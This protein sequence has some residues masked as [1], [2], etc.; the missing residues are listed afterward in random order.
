M[1]VDVD[2]GRDVEPVRLDEPRVF[3]A[4]NVRAPARWRSSEE[5]RAAL[6]PVGALEDEHVWLRVA[7]LQRL[8][9]DHARE[10]AW[11]EAFDAMLGYAR[12]HGWLDE[13]GI[14]VRA[15]LEWVG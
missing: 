5:L 9:G 6:T 13:R 8:A 10:R 1:I 2:P 11:T 12:E 3:T 4:L 7:E 15:H 14:A